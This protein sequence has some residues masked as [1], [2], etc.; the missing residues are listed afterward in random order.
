MQTN[1]GYL[2]SQIHKIGSRIFNNLLKT[3]QIDEFNGAQGII[4]YALWN[5]NILTIKEIAE[6]TGLAKTS[7]TTML[8]RMGE[9]GLI[10]KVENTKDKRSTKIKLTKKAKSL[11]SDYEDVTNKIS[12]IYYKDFTTSEIIEFEKKLKR[13]LNN[14]GSYHE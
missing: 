6:K 12:S 14:L 3:S 5:N 7:L 2:I 1:G 10:E 13:I 11:Q 8:D 4:L 9:K